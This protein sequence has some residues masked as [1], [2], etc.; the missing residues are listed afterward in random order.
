MGGKGGK[1]RR[2]QQRAI[3]TPAALPPVGPWVCAYCYT[4]QRQGE[5]TPCPACGRG[6][7]VRARMVP[8]ANGGDLF[9]LDEAVFRPEAAMPRMPS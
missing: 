8:P 2:Q 7:L 5:P 6:H 4:E 1:R 3:W 9:V